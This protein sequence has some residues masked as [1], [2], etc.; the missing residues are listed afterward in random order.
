VAKGVAV[1]L[2]ADAD[3]APGIAHVDN[4]LVQEFVADVVCAHVDLL[5]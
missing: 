4:D 1:S 5:D 2:S 3:H